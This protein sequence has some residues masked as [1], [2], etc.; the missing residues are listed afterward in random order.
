[1]QKL[2]RS[3]VMAS[4]LAF[5]GVLAGCGDDVTVKNPTTVTVT[6][7]SATLKVGETVTLTASVA[8]DNSNKAVTWST[9]DAAKASVSTDGKVTAI[10]AGNATITAT[11]AADAGAKSSALITITADKGV[12][13][14]TV[15]PSN[16]ILAPGQ[17]LQAGAT[18]ATTSGVAKTVMDT[19]NAI[20]T[21][22][23]V[24]PRWIV[25]VLKRA[26]GSTDAMRIAR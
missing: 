9:S 23:A 5:A 3:L 7:G 26:D 6:P 17:T 1:M 8:T 25:V 11:A 13:S 10:A 14:V 20:V 21:S 24:T 2:T 22:M 19:R 12:Q 15:A 18:V 4:A 16:A